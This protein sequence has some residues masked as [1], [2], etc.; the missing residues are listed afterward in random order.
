MEWRRQ[1]IGV[2]LTC[3]GGWLPCLEIQTV[4]LDSPLLC[5]WLVGLS[6]FVEDTEWNGCNVV[7]HSADSN[8]IF[9]HD[10]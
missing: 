6:V 7:S 10:V 5:D 4:G 2:L 3:S 9:E 8:L 1:M